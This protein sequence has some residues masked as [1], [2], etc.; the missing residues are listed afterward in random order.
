VLCHIPVS[1]FVAEDTTFNLI[2]RD[3]MSPA[4]T[5]ARVSVPALGVE[6]SKE[7]AVVTPDVIEVRRSFRSHSTGD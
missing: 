5:S 3:V 7:V 1:R 4:V 6:G 2:S